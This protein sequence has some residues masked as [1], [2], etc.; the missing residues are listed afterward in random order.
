MRKSSKTAEYGDYQTPA[1]LA[2]AVCRELSRQGVSPTALVEPTCGLGSFLLAALDEFRAV[3]HAV[4][5]D[6]NPT[7]IA[8]AE[9]LRCRRADRQ[10]LR[11]VAADFFETDW[12]AL[13]AEL[14]E[15]LLI[16]GNLPWVTNSHLSCL[17]SRN[18][19]EKSNF[20]NHAGLA[21]KTGKANFDISEWMLIRLMDAMRG[22]RGT[23]AILCKAAV[24]RKALVHGWKNR[25][26]LDRSAIHRID[27]DLHFD[28]AVDAA[29]LVTH[30]G[31]RAADKSATVY[32]SLRAAGAEAHIGL[33]DENLLADLDSY[34]RWKHLCGDEII[35][36]RSG[37]KHDC[38]K[39]ME[40]RRFGSRFRNGLGEIVDLEDAYVFPMMKSSHVAHGAKLDDDLCMLVTQR[41]IGEAT[42]R[43][44]KKAPRTWQYLMAHRALLEGRGSTIYRNRPPFSIFG[45]GSYTFAPWKV[46]ISGFYKKLAFS[47]VGQ[48]GEKPIVLD[49]TSYFLPCGTKAQ[50]E[51]LANMLNSTPAR[52]FY[53]AFVF[54]DT[55][56]PITAD[57][58]RKLDLRRLSEELGVHDRFE[59]L[60]SSADRE[61]LLWQR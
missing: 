60:C 13:I 31:D 19:P 1:P 45:V 22:R 54:W 58:L 27:A 47:V 41:S 3:R 14:P 40:L 59:A 5:V 32:P 15:P 61:P 26:P 55:K 39:V 25:I 7:Y 21:A 46:A 12:A 9:T 49:D 37:I 2:E 24:A 52:E 42:D 43:I 20:Q 10:K 23:L 30:F 34:Q 4:G 11:L 6:L 35:K 36:W 57:L 56:R 33:A 44:R 38:A 18:V 29:L 50:A 16:L 17:R 48:R 51:L 8:H 28:A 53:G